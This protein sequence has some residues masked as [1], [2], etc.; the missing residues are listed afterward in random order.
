MINWIKLTKELIKFGH[1]P[2]TWLPKD[3][4]PKSAGGGGREWHD[5][6]GIMLKD[7]DGKN[8]NKPVWWQP[9]QYIRRI[10]NAYAIPLPLRKISGNA[11]PEFMP[12]ANDDYPLVPGT[13]FKM[14]PHDFGDGKGTRMVRWVETMMSIYPAG[15]H[16][17]V[18]GFINGKWQECWYSRSWN[19][20]GNRVSI[21]AGLKVDQ[22]GPMMWYPEF[23]GSIKWGR[24]K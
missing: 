19:V 13:P 18:E 7:K 17:R 14:A 4:W 2:F 23:S 24:L 8:L 9:W 15:Q 21:Y 5:D 16:A 11:L 1:P 20:F 10:D 22:D 12:I 3:Y 6:W